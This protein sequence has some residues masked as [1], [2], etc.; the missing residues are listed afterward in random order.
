M[1]NPVEI[2]PDLLDRI[3]Q[4]AS[5][6]PDRPALSGHHG[7]TLRYRDLAV[8][9]LATAKGLRRNGFRSGDK[10]LFCVR[11]DPAGLVLL[12]GTVAAGGVIVFLDQHWDTETFAA[13]S[14]SVGAR[15]AA[16]DSLLYTDR[17]LRTGAHHLTLPDY[18]SLGIRTLRAGP[19]LPGV[20][21]GSLSAGALAKSR[22][23]T[24]DEPLPGLRGDP[25]A[26]AVVI[27]TSGT[28]AP[29][30]A[31]VHT[32][33]SLGAALTVLAARYRIDH[34]AEVFTHEL[35]VG[36]PALAAGAHWRL[37]AFGPSARMDPVRFARG[38]GRAT[39]TYL[40]PADLAA[41]L[42]A[43]SER[44]APKPQSLHH[45]L[46]GGAPALAPLVRRSLQVLPDAGVQSVYGR[47]EILAVAIADESQKL[48]P[49]GDGDP[50]GDL[51]PEVTARVSDEGELIVSGPSLAKG[52]LG[53]PEL[54]EFATGDLASLDG[55]ALVLHGR[56]RDMIV[57]GRT[58][59]FP[60]IYEPLVETVPGVGHAAL[61]GIPDE[62]GE[63][64]VVLAAQPA[65][66]RVN[67]HA[68]AEQPKESNSRGAPPAAAAA[69]SVLLDHPLAAVIAAALPG[70]IDL[71]SLPDD[72]VVVSSIPTIGRGR[73]PDRAALRRLLVA[74]SAG[75]ADDS[76]R[77]S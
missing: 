24:D 76:S 38:M 77:N 25:G 71:A 74:P 56:K 45:I 65:G 42:T 36:L 35:M 15:W 67:E 32:R 58:R 5:L 14:T 55:R 2:P 18:P 50:A 73:V 62:I 60:G 19:W 21:R 40:R 48:A 6:Y 10:M 3:L 69:F 4:A 28:A 12:L 43:I 26:E 41:L 53:G 1:T 9:V 22:H 72:I 63:E 31:V 30:K 13:R 47:T 17:K 34:R 57:R 7:R 75:P 68:L 23:P 37:P 49:R 64:R 59:I 27:H 54:T 33:G 20:P 51:L 46:L 29:V 52:Y 61:I 44:L 70:M 39:H 8:S 66:Q 11:P 16:N